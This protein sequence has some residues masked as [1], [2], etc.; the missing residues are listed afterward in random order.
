MPWVRVGSRWESLELKGGG[1]G[2]ILRCQGADLPTAHYT[3]H[4]Q[5]GEPSGLIAVTHRNEELLE[6]VWT[7]PCAI[8]R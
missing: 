2:G 1:A 7:R 3:F 5:S 6:K 4:W 8:A